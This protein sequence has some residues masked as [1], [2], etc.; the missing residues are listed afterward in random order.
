MSDW[1]ADRWPADPVNHWPTDP[2]MTDWHTDHNRLTH[3][4]TDRL[5]DRWLTATLTTDRLTHSHW[6][7]NQPMTNWH[8]DCWLADRL[9][10]WPT[11]W[12]ADSHTDRLTDQLTHWPLS[13]WPTHTLTDLP[14][15][16]LPSSLT[17]RPAYAWTDPFINPHDPHSD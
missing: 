6:P 15:H 16:W 13:G 9:T 3:S 11:D 7:I 17:D 5:T 10:H 2:P 4:H 1:H 12:L 8:T 14:S